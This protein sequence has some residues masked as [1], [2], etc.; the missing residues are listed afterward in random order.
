MLKFTS[1][2]HFCVATLRL[3]GR[4]VEQGKTELCVILI[5][6]VQIPDPISVTAAEGGYHT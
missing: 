5:I 3:T 4:Q 1:T 6:V 2:Q